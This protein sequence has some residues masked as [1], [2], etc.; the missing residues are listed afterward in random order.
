M[1]PTYYIVLSA[2]LFTIGTIGFMVRRNA[3]VAFMCATVAV[4]GLSMAP[5]LALSYVFVALA[6]LGS[7]GT[8]T[9]VSSMVTR[10]YAPQ[11]RAG[12]LGVTL[13]V[14][15]AGAMAGPLVGG[16]IVGSSLGF[17]A[18][19]VVFAIAAVLGALLVAAV[20]WSRR[21][22]SATAPQPNSARTVDV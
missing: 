8:Q 5:P 18:N 16:W 17:A 3:I 12:A 21:H 20:P 6:G 9:L 15:R 7:T 1:S 11:V 2:I 14:G 22:Q 19:F 4:I 13:A 10:Y